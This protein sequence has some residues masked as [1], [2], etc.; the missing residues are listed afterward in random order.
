MLFVAI[1]VSFPPLILLISIRFFIY[2][3]STINFLG[4]GGG[5]GAPFFGFFIFFIFF[6]GRGGFGPGF[7]LFGG[8]EEEAQI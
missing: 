8:G 6:G 7:W 2:T 4:E 5:P 1:F 3:I